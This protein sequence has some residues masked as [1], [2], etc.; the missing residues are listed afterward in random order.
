MTLKYNFSEVMTRQPCKLLEV[1]KIV[2]VK[3]F[4]KKKNYN[5]EI[6]SPLVVE[7]MNGK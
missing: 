1:S 7:M 2:T 4:T 6:L 5:S 3:K